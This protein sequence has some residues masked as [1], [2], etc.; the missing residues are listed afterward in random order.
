[1]FS[2]VWGYV[3][4]WAITAV[5][6][7]PGDVG[8]MFLAYSV[9]SGISGFGGGW[10]SDRVGRRSVMIVGWGVASVLIA[11]LPLARSSVWL[12]LSLA[13]LAMVIGAP[14][15]S[16]CATVIS[17]LTDEGTREQAYAATRV[18]FNIGSVLG[19]PLAAIVLIARSW[20]LLFVAGSAVGLITVALVLMTL[21]RDHP[22]DRT[23][24][25]VAAAPRPE[26]FVIL[27]DR[28]FLL[29]LLSTLLGWFIYVAFSY[30]L[31]VVAVADYH[32]DPVA[33]GF[34]AAI[35]PII[36]VLFQMRT[37]RWTAGF[38][39]SGKLFS[40]SL[41]MGMP[42]LLLVV[43]PNAWGVVLLTLLFVVGEM[44]WAP[45]SQSLSVSMAP[46]SMRGSY[47]GAFRG[48]SQVAM[49]LAPFVVLRVY[50]LGDDIAWVLL[51]VVSVLAAV[52]GWAAAAVAKRTGR[53][54]QQT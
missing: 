26:R 3:G 15:T 9:A 35:N 53:V 4:V 48:V 14:A 1:M 36:V 33:W 52:G 6:A 31:P 2:G 44:L 28:P 51:A 40:A 19:P 24:P 23:A 37:S 25:E 41:L 42:F 8:V 7:S 43:L 39:Q 45:V 21:P 18:M 10:L 34:I 16:A 50:E 13:V 30:V 38:S 22:G 46:G 11:V 29:L 47:M 5:Q 32:T 27:R 49:G 54:G 17:D 12:A 20:T